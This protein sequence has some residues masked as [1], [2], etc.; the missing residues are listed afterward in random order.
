MRSLHVITSDARRGAETFAVG[1]AR[2]LSQG[3]DVA[4]VV[5]L[6]PAAEGA[7][8]DVP[9][10]GARRRSVTTLRNLRRAARSADVVVAHGSST[11]EACAVGLR[12]TG[13][14]FAYRTIGDPSYW[15]TSPRR[16][17][18]V[19]VMLQQ[20][21]LNVVLWPGAASQLVTDFGVPADRIQVIANA[22][23][24][25][26]FPV[27]SDQDRAVSRQRFGVPDGA[28]CLAFVGALS[29]EKGV[30][31]I[32][33]AVGE[34]EEVVVLIAGD[35]P[36]RR[37]LEKRAQDLPPG[38]VRFLG[39]VTDPIAVYAAADLVLLP[40]R[41]E[42]M[43]GVIIEAGLCGTATVA[44]AVGAVPHMLEDGVTGF[45]TRPD[46]PGYLAATIRTALPHARSAGGRAAEH[47]ATGYT[48]ESVA[49][50]WRGALADLSRT[51]VDD[52]A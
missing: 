31:A 32:V 1:L 22:V 38:R 30:D 5:A 49:E 51:G 15:V 9:L 46:D 14:P 33:D 16:R 18:L 40:S 28:P 24:Q 2:Q 8:L 37:L 45:L 39:P 29:P 48:L 10:L 52:G 26:E 4:R 34:L 36:D 42:G 13:I 19:R 43:P 17:R 35:G 3:G 20:A 50:A 23:P 11:L 27:V 44:S 47:F 6:M 41:T 21:S 7:R 12:G 25:A